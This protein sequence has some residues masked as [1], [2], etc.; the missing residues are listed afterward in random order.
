MLPTTKTVPT[1]N[2]SSTPRISTIAASGRTTVN[3]GRSLESLYPSSSLLQFVK[4]RVAQHEAYNGPERRLELRNLLVM[5]VVVQAVNAQLEPM[6]DAQAMVISDASSSGIGMVH[7]HPFGHTRILIHLSYPEDGKVLAAEVRWS[8]PLGPFYH[9]GCELI[10]PLK[11]PGSG[12]A[13]ASR[14]R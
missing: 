1:G 14:T 6:G 11:A 3:G 7:E 9:I 8:K 2:T 12:Q 13:T 10:G 4:R 5:P